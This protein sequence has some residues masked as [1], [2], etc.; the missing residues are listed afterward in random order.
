M[1]EVRKSTLAEDDLIEIWLFSYEQW[2]ELQAEKYFDEI[3]RG[4][5]RLA[6]NPE[7]GKPCDY[8]REGY[9]ELSLGEHVV[10]YTIEASSIH[11]I[12]VL[13]GRMDPGRHL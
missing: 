6:D 8:I 7:L 5:D 4:I 1:H 3:E 10:Y 11:V 13:H 9:R 2:G 12:R